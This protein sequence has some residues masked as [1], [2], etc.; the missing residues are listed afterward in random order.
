MI[1]II[2]MFYKHLIYWIYN[3]LGLKRRNVKIDDLE[4]YRSAA[5]IPRQLPCICGWDRWKTKIKGKLY[6]CRGCGE[7]VRNV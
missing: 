4:N 1:K 2:F 5:Y 7:K 6:Q 3:A